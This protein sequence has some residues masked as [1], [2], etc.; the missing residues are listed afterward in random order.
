FQALSRR[1][2]GDRPFAAA[3]FQDDV[4]QP[5]LALALRPGVELVE[6]AAWLAGGPGGADGAHDAAGGNDAREHFEV[7]A[8]EDLADVYDPERVAQVGLVGAPGQQR[9]GIGNAGKRQGRHL[10]RR[11][12]TE[13][14]EFLEDAAQY[15]LDGGKHVVLRHEAHL[16][17]ELV[18]L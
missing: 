7:G 13:L 8:G 4:A 6:E 17:V 10:P 11:V 14:G 5:R 15:R 9:L 3:A 12:A 2:L 18:E 1:E 16:E